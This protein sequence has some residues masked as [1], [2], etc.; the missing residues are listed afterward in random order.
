MQRIS[1]SIFLS[2]SFSLLSLVLLVYLARYILRSPRN[3]AAPVCWTTTTAACAPCRE[4]ADSSSDRHRA[5]AECSV[6]QCERSW[7]SRLACSAW[8]KIETVRCVRGTTVALSLSPSV[9]EQPACVRAWL[10]ASA[11]P[12]NNRKSREVAREP[13]IEDTAVGE[14]VSARV[15]M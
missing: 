6:F 2:L 4:C 8:W 13:R 3:G 7:D 12:T 10:R 1:Q 9:C 14:Q 11:I 15:Y 5:A